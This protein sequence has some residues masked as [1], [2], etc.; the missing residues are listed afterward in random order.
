MPSRPLRG[1]RRHCTLLLR[2]L[3]FFLSFVL[4]PGRLIWKHVCPLQLK[5]NAAICRQLAFV[6]AT[7][8]DPLEFSSA[9]HEPPPA[10]ILGRTIFSCDLPHDSHGQLVSGIEGIHL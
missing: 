2:C 9:P 8:F 7:T 5:C 10:L 3:S 4:V 1:T 6:T